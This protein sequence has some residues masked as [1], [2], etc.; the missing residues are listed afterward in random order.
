MFFSLLK[1]DFI[2]YLSVDI[3]FFDIVLPKPV[4]VILF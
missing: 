3:K 2:P 1:P 4:P